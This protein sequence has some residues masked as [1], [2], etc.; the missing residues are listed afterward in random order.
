M[1]RVGD[2]STRLF[3]F[4]L[5]SEIDT[6]SVECDDHCLNLARSQTVLTFFKFKFAAQT[7]TLFA[8]MNAS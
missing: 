7:L 4:D 2:P 8:D 6:H 5:M 1:R 3:C